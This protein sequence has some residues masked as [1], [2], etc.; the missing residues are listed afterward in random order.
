MHSMF[1]N[2]ARRQVAA[3]TVEGGSDQVDLHRILLPRGPPGCTKG[4]SA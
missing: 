3:E 2:W 4:S 1:G